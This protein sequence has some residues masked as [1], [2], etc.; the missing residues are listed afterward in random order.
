MENNNTKVS[1]KLV[2]TGTLMMASGMVLNV[3]I[4][5]YL[6]Y[7]VFDILGNSPGIIEILFTVFSGFYILIIMSI[8][9]I[10]LIIIGWVF[11][12]VDR[13]EVK[14]AGYEIEYQLIWL[15]F[16][17][18]VYL[19]RR[20][21]ALKDKLVYPIIF[22]VALAITITGSIVYTWVSNYN[23]NQL[24][25]TIDNEKEIFIEEFYREFENM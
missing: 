14:K 4:Q 5:S 24:G 22:A 12:F 19:F 21:F 2:W 13:L 23:F 8:L 1:N 3:F 20:A 6:Q 10:F 7:R 18:V 11:L 15:I 25:E 16:L 17:P 9:A